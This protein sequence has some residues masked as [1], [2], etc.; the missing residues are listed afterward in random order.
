MLNDSERMWLFVLTIG[1]GA[2]LLFPLVRAL[3]ARIRSQPDSGLREE[4]RAAHRHPFGSRISKI[5]VAAPL[6]YGLIRAVHAV[7]GS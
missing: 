1:A 6:A 2:A 5:A 7:L 3:A 4:V